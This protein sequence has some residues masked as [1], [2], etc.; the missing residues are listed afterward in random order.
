MLQVF[1]SHAEHLGPDLFM[2]FCV[3]YLNQICDRVKASLGN[4]A[5]PMVS[6]NKRPLVLLPAAQRLR[7]ILVFF[8][9]LLGRRL[10]NILFLLLGKVNIFTQVPDLFLLYDDY[11]PF[12]DPLIFFENITIT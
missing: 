9:Y 7:L 1:E 8:N 6:Q 4:D 10:S 5:V 12:N 11:I 2:E 3:P